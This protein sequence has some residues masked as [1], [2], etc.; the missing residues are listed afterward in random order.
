MSIS[1][2]L[3]NLPVEILVQILLR[4]K[5]DDIIH[6]CEVS[7]KFNQICHDS[8][9]W[10]SKMQQDFSDFPQEFIND[11]NRRGIDNFNMYRLLYQYRWLKPG[12]EQQVIFRLN[13]GENN[14][15]DFIINSL[16][17]KE[18]KINHDTDIVVSSFEISDVWNS[19][20]SDGKQRLLFRQ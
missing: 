1:G 6:M 8:Q 14:I 16:E 4:S 10:L 11:M 13:R 17:E 9:V 12:F 5:F 19:V 20:G 2:S 3:D 15:A 7:R 18:I